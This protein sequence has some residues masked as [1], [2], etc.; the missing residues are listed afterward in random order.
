MKLFFFISHIALWHTCNL[1]DAKG[2]FL[3]RLEF[4]NLSFLYNHVLDSGLYFH[5]LCFKRNGATSKNK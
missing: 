3:G 5:N 2:L 1:L 4:S